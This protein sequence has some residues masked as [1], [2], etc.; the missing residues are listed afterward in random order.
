MPGARLIKVGGALEPG[1]DRLAH[2]LGVADAI[3]LFPFLDRA[4]L[5]AVYRRAAL[6]SWRTLQRVVETCERDCAGQ[7]PIVCGCFRA[8][9]FT[10]AGAR[11][12]ELPCRSTGLT[13]LPLTRS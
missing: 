10:E 13:A 6:M 4:L 8:Y 9:S 1:Q 3:V 11:R 2:A 12:S 7:S 5:A